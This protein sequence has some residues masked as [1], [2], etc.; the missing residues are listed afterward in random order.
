M[1]IKVIDA[2]CGSG[3]TG[4]MLRHMARNHDRKYLFVTPLLTESEGRIPVGFKEA[5]LAITGKKSM[6]YKYQFCVPTVLKDRTKGEHMKE[7]V[8]QGRNISTTHSLFSDM[9]RDVVNMLIEQNYVLVIDEAIECIGTISDQYNRSDMHALLEGDFVSAE[10][11][12]E[13]GRLVWHEDKYPNHDGKY[14]LVRTLC[15]MGSLHSFD[16]RFL[17]VEYPSALLT[18]LQDVYVLT[19]MFHA[20]DMRCWLNLNGIPYEYVDNKELGVEREAELLEAARQGIQVLQYKKLDKL[21][22]QQTRS[23]LSLSWYLKSLVKDTK[24][25]KTIME[26][27]VNTNDVKK[28]QVYWTT[29]KEFEG[30]MKGKGYTAGPNPETPAWIAK[31]TRATNAYKDFQMSMFACNSYRNPLI[32]RYLSSH[33]VDY[34]YDEWSTSELVQF[35]FRGR[36]RTLQPQKVVIL[37]RRMAELF[38]KWRKSLI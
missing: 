16:G 17:M 26:S 13:R 5:Y 27:I 25:Y 8:A 12:S 15:N 19:Y 2:I 1:T 29:F 22:S 35:I 7:L 34:A 10:E 23:S 24:P 30:R 4:A 31:N 37:S 9:P 3:K 11:G 28:G 32:C 33:G 20:S 38:E 6:D 21:M 18:G 36:I 14:K